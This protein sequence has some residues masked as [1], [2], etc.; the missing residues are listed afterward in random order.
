MRLLRLISFHHSGTPS[1]LRPWPRMLSPG[2]MLDL[3]HV[4]A[5]VTEDLAAQ[6]SGEDRGHVQDPQSCQR[7]RRDW[8]RWSLSFRS[9]ERCTGL[10][11]DLFG[12]R[13]NPSIGARIM[14]VHWHRG[15][16]SVDRGWVRNLGSSS[17]SDA[18]SFRQAEQVRATG[19]LAGMA[20][21]LRDDD[22]PAVLEDRARLVLHDLFSVTL[23]G[24]RT[25]EL[26]ATRS[27]PPG[28][29]AEPCGP[30]ALHS[31]PHPSPRRSWTRWRPAAS[32]S[33]RATSTPPA[34]RP[35]TSSSPRWRRLD[36][37]TSRW[38]VGGSSQP[39]SR[40]TRWRPGS[41]AR[42]TAIRGWHT[43]GHWGAT[44][45]ATA[46]ALVLGADERPGGGGDRRLDLADPRHAVAGRA[47]GRLRAQPVDRRGQPCRARRRPAGTRRARHR[48]RVPR[49]TRSVTSWAGW[50]RTG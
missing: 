42:W 40:A 4:R 41:A 22:L 19:G 37:P 47:G 13:V 21:S 35:R 2:R 33:T 30:S 10:T 44:G 27:H 7:G 24:A 46:A 38:T 45:A 48:H 28:C 9:E 12:R 1:L 26:G 36:C 20:V 11:L 25:P 17:W 34:T 31:R 29:A 32:S 50:T 6:R 43:H 23:A 8:S 18:E 15:P 49:S 39:W 14:R 5:E 16:A 3:D